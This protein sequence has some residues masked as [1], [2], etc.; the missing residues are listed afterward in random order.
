[1]FGAKLCYIVATSKLFNPLILKEV[2]WLLLPPVGRTIFSTIMCKMH[3]RV[4]SAR[5][6][7]RANVKPIAKSTKQLVLLRRRGRRSSRCGC[8]G[9]WWFSCRSR[10]LFGCRCGSRGLFRCRPTKPSS[11]PADYGQQD[12]DGDHGNYS[13]PIVFDLCHFVLAFFHGLQAP[14]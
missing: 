13:V 11:R 6:V 9:R 10:R 14:I 3:A 12:D 5:V 2:K 7:S 4:M 8:R 1:M